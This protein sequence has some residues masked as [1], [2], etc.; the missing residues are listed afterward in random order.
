[1]K[2]IYNSINTRYRYHDHIFQFKHKRISLTRWSISAVVFPNRSTGLTFMSNRF[3]EFKSRLKMRILL[4]SNDK[5][6][7][8]DFFFFGKLCLNSW[9]SL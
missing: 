8:T 2:Y 7:G 5:H 6:G 9:I 4:E 1:M 3:S